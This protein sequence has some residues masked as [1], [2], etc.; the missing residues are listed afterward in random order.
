VGCAH[1][2]VHRRGRCGRSQFRLCNIGTCE[3]RKSSR[4]PHK[5]S[6]MYPPAH[7]RRPPLAVRRTLRVNHDADNGC[8]T[9]TMLR[10]VCFTKS[11]ACLR[12]P[13]PRCGA[14][15]EA[16]HGPRGRVAV[17]RDEVIDADPVHRERRALRRRARPITRCGSPPRSRRRENEE[18]WGVPYGRRHLRRQGRAVGTPRG[19]SQFRV[20]PAGSCFRTADPVGAW[21][22]LPGG[23][24]GSERASCSRACSTAASRRSPTGSRKWT[25]S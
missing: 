13:V 9:G 24:A 25:G 11:S 20:A 18:V 22:H 5:A 16:G 17:A 6:F 1:G 10:L 14:C 19:T 3:A 7:P 2:S 4:T 15:R 23:A 12:V 21:R 8:D